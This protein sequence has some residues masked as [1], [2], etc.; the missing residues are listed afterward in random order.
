[1]DEDGFVADCSVSK[2]GGALLI[3]VGTV[4][5]AVALALWLA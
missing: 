4:T 1:M 5:L 3:A 2:Y